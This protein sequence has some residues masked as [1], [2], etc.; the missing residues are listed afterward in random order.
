MTALYLR[1]SRDDGG[2]SESE[3]IVNQR[4]FLLDYADRNGLD[5]IEIYADD[6]VSGTTFE[7]PDFKRMIDDVEGGRINTI[8]TKDLSRFGRDYIMT[9]Y[10][11]EKYFPL[12]NVRYIA[13]NDGVDTFNMS[14]GD[15][16]PFRAVFNDIY[17]KD[18]SQKV[19]TALTTKKKNG[20]FIG[21]VSP[22]GY[23]KDLENKNKLII[24][25]E[26]APYV[27]KIFELYLSGMNLLTISN[28]LTQEGI[29]TPSQAKGLAAT[30]KRF[31]G[32]WNDNIIKRIL[33]NPT[34]IGNL[35][36]NR[37]R[38]AGYKVD[39]KIRLPKNEW[40]IVENTHE[41]II[42]KEDFDAVQNRMAIRSY[43]NQSRNAKQHLL[44]GLT[45]CADCGSPMS[46]VKE[47]S[48]RYYLICGA[49]R[50]HAK[51]GLC[52]SHCIREDAVVNEVKKQLKWLAEKFIDAGRLADECEEII[53]APNEVKAMAGLEKRILEK[54]KIKF[55][56]YSDKAKGIISEADYIAFS[57]EIE[58][59]E[60]ELRTRIE[61]LTARYKEHSVTVRGMIND[62]LTF[63]ELDRMS[64]V[65][66]VK[67]IEIGKEK[68]IIIE[69]AFS[70]PQ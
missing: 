40:I 30:Q 6:G 70:E 65:S 8:I 44:S 69:F 67:R 47:S 11:L 42:S 46:T 18:I 54:G 7:R 64:L 22:Y 33:T 57:K 50:R 55:S 61:S 31:P 23:K 16:T 2:D 49:W 21:S 39:K 10:Y 37:S 34:Y 60:L 14:S 45:Y 43:D 4:E 9:G 13:V 56:L 38:K 28:Q 27:R 48:S 15:M 19:R 25:E 52:T 32:L 1:L 26:T 51:I 62:L 35:T 29:P 66:L 20:A 5:V 3:S 12:K 58:R 63:E 41:G 17:T 68:A 36:Q 53:S 59:E 24:D